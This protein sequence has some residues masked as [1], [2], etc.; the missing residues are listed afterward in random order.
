MD[1]GFVSL[2]TAEKNHDAIFVIILSLLGHADFHACQCLPAAL[3]SRV[4]GSSTM[5]ILGSAA[6]EEIGRAA[7][8]DLR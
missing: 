8:C 3:R 4:L 1:A 6:A 2:F 7:V 5:A